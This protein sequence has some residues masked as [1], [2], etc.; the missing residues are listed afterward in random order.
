MAKKK[1]R[2]VDWGTPAK[3]KVGEHIRFHYVVDVVDG[4]IVEDR[5]PIGVGGRRLYGITFNKNPGQDSYIEL[6]EVDIMPGNS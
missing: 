6:P 4:L 5:G 2:T 3:F 1:S